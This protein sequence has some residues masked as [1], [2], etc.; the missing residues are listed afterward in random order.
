VNAGL[1]AIGGDD[2][3]SDNV[4]VN[5]TN[6]D[7]IASVTGGGTDVQVAGLRPWSR[8]PVASP[9]ATG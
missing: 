8:C 4:L 2:G 6:G 7:D 3:Q 5:A 9:A 1:A